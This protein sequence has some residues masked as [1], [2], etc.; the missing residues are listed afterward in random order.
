MNLTNAYSNFA[1]MK[2]TC[3]RELR[4]YVD[5][6][7][8]PVTGFGHQEDRPCVYAF[9]TPDDGPVKIGSTARPIA[10]L[11][12]LRFGAAPSYAPEGR[13]D[14][15]YYHLEPCRTKRECLM[16]ER[17]AQNILASHRMR[18]KT[19]KDNRHFKVEWFDAPLLLIRRTI[20]LAVVVVE[21]EI[22]DPNTDELLQMLTGS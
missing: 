10:R 13:T 22:H 6:W 17:L 8:G 14:G 20:Q 7:S 15:R 16:S 4:C 9:A 11:W 1:D 18:F 19:V 5:S 21:G 3:R 2:A 12:Q